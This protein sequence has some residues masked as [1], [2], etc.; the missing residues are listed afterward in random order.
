MKSRMSEKETQAERIL[1]AQRD[2]VIALSTINTL[3]EGLH[4]CLDTALEVGEMDAGGIYIADKS[5]GDFDLMIHKKLS[6]EFINTALYYEAD[7]DNVKLMNEGNPVYS[8][9]EN[10]GIFL[11]EPVLAEGLSA[12][13]FLP[14]L[15]N[16][17]VIGCLNVASKYHSEVPQYSRVALEA[18]S[19]HIGMSVVRMEAQEELKKATERLEQQVQERTQELQASE[20]KY[21]SIFE[22]ISSS[23]IMTDS[24]GIIVDINPYHLDVISRGKVTK[25][26]YLGKNLLDFPSIIAAG[27]REDYKRVFAGESLEL[28]AVYFPFITAGHAGYFNVKAKPLLRNGE[29]VGTLFS[30]TEVTEKKLAEDAL[31]EASEFREKIIS[32]S[33]VPTSIYDGKTGE[34]VATNKAMAA[35]VGTTEEKLLA[36]NYNDIESWR[37]SGLLEAVKDS[38]R[39]NEAREFEIDHKTTL[40]GKDISADCLFAP[41]YAKDKQ[42]LLF[43]L[44]DLAERKKAE[45]EKIDLEHQMLHAQ[46]LESLGVLAGGIAHDFNN[47]LMGVLGNAELSLYKLPPESPVRDNLHDIVSAATRAADLAKQ[48]LAYSGQGRFHIEAVNVNRMVEEMTHLLNTTISKNVILKFNFTENIPS[49]EADITQVRQVFMN[50]ITNASEAIEDKSG[51]V[52]VSTGVMEVTE[53]YLKG[54]FVNEDVTTGYYTFI[55]VSDTGMGMDKE[56]QN[57]V[58]DPFFSTKFTGRGLGMAATLGIIRGHN[59]AIK[60]YSEPGK[61]TTFKVLFPCGDDVS[62]ELKPNGKDISDLKKW[63][64]EDTIL[65]VDDEETVRAISKKTLIPRGFT[66]LTSEDGREA[67]KVFSE[68]SESITLV[69]LDITMPHMGGEEVYTELRKIRPDV[70]VILSSGYDEKEVTNRFAG[71]GLAGFIQKPY[72]PSELVEKLREVLG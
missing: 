68:N 17:K 54:V 20:E 38:I 43:S 42:Y 12:I 8:Q 27:L 10:S 23:V 21:R 57:K 31:K 22:T 24:E 67:I 49:I 13:A 35:F 6:P 64:S 46:K 33:P 63:R 65:V 15:S 4:V 5:T 11:E 26:D 52:T 32:E 44:R 18:I 53:E 40:G 56:I 48:M 37:K 72:R 60:V 30:V 39:D 9:L 36:T 25:E 41:F 29:M 7:S 28:S 61:G 19:G 62:E 14:V 71:K 16:G 50:L 66:V 51:V 59:G 69:L 58:F 70:K 55:E 3:D 34:C 1:R 2:L 45:K 47:I